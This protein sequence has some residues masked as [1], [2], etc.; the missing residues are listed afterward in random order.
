MR[1]PL[2]AAQVKQRNLMLSF[3]KLNNYVWSIHSRRLKSDTK[4]KS[5]QTEL[6]KISRHARKL[7]NSSELVRS[8]LFS[9]GTEL[10]EC[11]PME[12]FLA[13]PVNQRKVQGKK[14]L[15]QL[16]PM[17]FFCQSYNPNGLLKV[18]SEDLLKKKMTR[19][20]TEQSKEFS[21]LDVRTS[22]KTD[23]MH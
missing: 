19:Q 15:Q 21:L 9:Y 7:S 22:K 1:E 23:Q 8:C 20:M 6:R 12:Y 14:I 2:V 17:K 16:N 4:K 5:A 10:Q 11:N 18:V 3:L 13:F